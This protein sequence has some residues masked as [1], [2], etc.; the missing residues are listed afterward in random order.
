M[1]KSIR[2]IFFVVVIANILIC[3]SFAMSFSD[4]PSNS[5]YATAIN[6]VSDAGLMVGVSDGKFMPGK[7]VTRAEMATL[8]CRMM[9]ETNNLSTSRK[10]SDVPENSWAN[11]YVSKASQL[12]IVN[13]YGN[14][15]FGPW[16]TVTYEQAVTMIVRAKGLE[17][18]A[19]SVG[20]YPD[21]Y[22]RVADAN[23]YLKNLHANVG[24]LLRR[25]EVALI[26]YNVLNPNSVSVVEL[27]QIGEYIS[28]DYPDTLTIYEIYDGKVRFSVDWF[29]GPSLDD[30]VGTLD[31]DAARFDTGVVAGY[32]QFNSDRIVMTIS[33]SN[34]SDIEKKTTAFNYA[35]M[36]NWQKKIITSNTEETMWVRVDRFTSH[37]E[38]NLRFYSDGRIEWTVYDI[39][40]N[41]DYVGGASSTHKYSGT[42]ELLKGNRISINGT[43]YLFSVDDR[44]E[45]TGTMI[46]IEP[47]QQDVNGL[48]G[49]FEFM[50]VS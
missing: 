41:G 38:T 50:Q 43:V 4:V 7:N 47:L 48:A 14:G 36:R 12:G 35:D 5:E 21:G 45:F 1:K 10:Y 6:F 15:R 25:E 18:N 46:Y 32:I 17:S 39:D 31:W 28:E 23:R 26:L 44:N 19:I 16:D 33:K 2:T 27:P 24:D 20:G 34:I 13:G 3:S 40:W 42:Y 22:I 37:T 9:G 11:I 29:R 30:V 8:V 49:S